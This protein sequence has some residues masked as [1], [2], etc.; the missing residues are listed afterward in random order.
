M[1][2]RVSSRCTHGPS[3]ALRYADA[4]RRVYASSSFV[5]PEFAR[6]SSAALPPTEATSAA[7]SDSWDLDAETDETPMGPTAHG[8][9]AS[10]GNAAYNFYEDF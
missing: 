1:Y 10:N 3:V 7:A 5:T 8:V 9:P 4:V 2:I 6:K